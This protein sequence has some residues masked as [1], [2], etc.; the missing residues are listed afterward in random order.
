[1]VTRATNENESKM[2]MQL[3]STSDTR[4]R[5]S[6][7]VIPLC[8]LCIAV[9]T[10]FASGAAADVVT[11]PE[12][13]RGRDFTMEF[14]ARFA[15]GAPRN[16][17]LRLG[18]AGRPGVQ[19]DKL[20]FSKTSIDF[21]GNWTRTLDFIG[22]GYTGTPFMEQRRFLLPF[23]V[24]DGAWHHVRVVS[25]GGYV[26]FFVQ[27]GDKL[28][29]TLT[30]VLRKDFSLAG[31]EFILPDGVEVANVKVGP[32]DEGDV[33]PP[34]AGYNVCRTPRTVDIPL[35]DGQASFAFIPG[36][37]PVEVMLDFKDGTTNRLSANFVSFCES[38]THHLYNIER[39]DKAGVEEF[40]RGGFV[41]QR[42][43]SW[44]P[45]CRLRLRFPRRLFPPLP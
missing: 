18:S 9:L 45:F 30:N 44:N 8:A 12:E 28:Q 1:M 36:G 25:D 42:L 33:P 13:Q 16:L 7:L 11:L 26:T 20:S 10:V 31:Y 4:I 27:F 15:H 23:E 43:Q 5:H 3:H 41:L 29:R 37:Y 22:S 40:A 35:R 14:D 19:P 21:A 38:F 6:S 32:F 2:T 39:R 24:P 17:V 34:R